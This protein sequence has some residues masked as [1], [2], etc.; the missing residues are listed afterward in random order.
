LGSSAWPIEPTT[1]VLLG[2]AGV[3]LLCL[4][5]IG[6]Y[7]QRIYD[8]TRSRPRWIVSETSTAANGVSQPATRAA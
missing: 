7:L 5:L 3:Q 1:L 2:V 4:G 8:E 6:N